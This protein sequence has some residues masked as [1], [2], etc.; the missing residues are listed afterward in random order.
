[1]PE[2]GSGGSGS[3]AR[4][5]RPKPRTAKALLTALVALYIL[6]HGYMVIQRHRHFNSHLF[7]LGVQDQ[8]VWNTANGR[9][10]QSSIEVNNYLGDHF[11]PL[12]ALLSLFYLIRPSVYW[13]LMFQTFVLALGAIPVYRLANRHLGTAAG[14]LVFAI[15]YLAH[16][17]IGNVNRFDFHWE[18]TVV[19][20]FL[21]AIDAVETGRLK[22]AFAS[23]LLAT[24]GKEEI[25]LTTA[26][27]GL[28]RVIRD[29]SRFG[30][31][32]LI[33]GTAFSLTALLVVIPAFRGGPA[34]TLDRYAWLG[35]TPWQMIRTLLTRPGFIFENVAWGDVGRYFLHLLAPL[36]F[37]PLLA[38]LSLIP[39][40]PSTVYNLLSSLPVQRTVFYQYI[41]PAVPFTIMAAIHGAKVVVKRLEGVSQSKTRTAVL[42]ALLACAA[43]GA[44]KTSPLLQREN[45]SRLPNERA[46]YSALS[47]VPDNASVMTTDPY[48]PHLSHRGDLEL[49]SDPEAVCATDV[50]LFN[51][52]DHRPKLSPTSDDYTYSDAQYAQG[53]KNAEECGFQELFSSEGVI[54]LQRAAPSQP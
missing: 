9:W 37:L 22:R 48:A 50:I 16:P 36:A 3:K 4:L 47:L 24:L 46:V 42:A 10:Y 5:K 43:L 49:F 20:L 7:D 31:F 12:L 33:A 30:L 28:Q 29:R 38:P 26:A 39:L 2:P 41:A 25:G 44:L 52:K 13:L 40:L 1:M 19:P 32:W 34:D 15:A 11:Q 14:G 35:S 8:V 23:L 6:S 45:W 27:Y 17:S 18:V 53:L 21:A 54:L 51:L